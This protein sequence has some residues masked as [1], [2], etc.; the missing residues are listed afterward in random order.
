MNNRTYKA[1]EKDDMLETM[2]TATMREDG[3]DEARPAPGS[4]LEQ[5]AHYEELLLQCDKLIK[6]SG[7]ILVAYMKEFG[8]MLVANFE[9]KVECIKEKKRISYCRRRM[10]RGL[11][12]DV[13]KMDSEIEKEMK[14]YIFQLNDMIE[15]TEEAKNAS[16]VSEYLLSRAK[17]IYRRLAKLLH[18]DINERT[19]EDAEL[20]EL[21]NRIAQAYRMSEVDE[22]EDL[23]LLVR[24]VMMER[25][26]ETFVVVCKD[27]EQR[28]ERVERQINEIL[29]T[30]PYTYREL[31]SDEARIQEYKNRLQE[32]HDDYERYLELLR[33]S[34]EEMLQG[35]GAK[36][37]WRLD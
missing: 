36:L 8:E 9:L 12:V 5:L 13:E 2:D 15:E 1:N 24:K 10:N 6:E 37:Q 4:E 33:K 11:A 30:E 20:K 26:V 3:S 17:K 18:P 23:E 7:S 28:I 22:L 35:G 21:W 34:L 19:M 25:G 16:H 14:L 29:S 27:L 31:L 32:E